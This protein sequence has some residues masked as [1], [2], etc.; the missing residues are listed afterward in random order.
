V[1]IVHE[2]S[3]T[4]SAASGTSLVINKPTGTAA[5]DLLLA[6]VYKTDTPT[7]PAGWVFVVDLGFGGAGGGGTLW[8]KI[9][10]SSEPASYTITQA[11]SGKIAGGISR[12]SGVDNTTPI[13][14]TPSYA[15]GTG[16]GP[17]ATAVTTVTAN[18]MV[19]G[20]VAN[21]NAP[22]VT[23]PGSLTERWE[24]QGVEH[25]SAV[26]AAAG[27]TG[28]K[29]WTN[30]L[31]STYYEVFLT[32]LRPASGS[33]QTV[34]GAG[35]ASSEALGTSTVMF[36]GLSGVG[37][38]S[39]AAMGQATLSM[40]LTVAGSGIG[41]VAGVGSATLTRDSDPMDVIYTWGVNRRSRAVRFV[42]ETMEPLARIRVREFEVWHRPSG[43][44]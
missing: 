19:V 16:T 24:I 28:S 12:Y 33:V 11:T 39:S 40:G 44:Q 13:D 32:A 15:S 38:P 37:I 26:Q 14:C 36:A 3:A 9:A 35:V 18:A 4:N 31:S 22:A 21:L 34:T 7:F 42:F 2:S 8:Y 10:G 30:S 17:V 23:A 27:S 20:G 41:S 29:T 1:A 43:R 25:A 6:W 5:G